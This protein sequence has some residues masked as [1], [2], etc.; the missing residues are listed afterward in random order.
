MGEMN[1]TIAI[2]GLHGTGKSTF[3]K[4]VA[5][6][7]GLRH[8]SVGELFRQMASEQHLSLTELSQEVEKRD[9]IDRLLDERTMEEIRKGSVVVDSLLASWMMKEHLTLKIYLSAPFE[10]RISRIASRDETSY[11]EAEKATVLRERIERRRFK[12]LY[13]IDIDDLGHVDTLRETT[14]GMYISRSLGGVPGRT[15]SLR[16]VVHGTEYDAG[17]VD[18][19]YFTVKN[20]D[21]TGWPSTPGCLEDPDNCENNETVYKGSATNQ[22]R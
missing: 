6:E 5:K 17:D 10:T 21:A 2:S 22:R 3:A 18:A 1:L 8:V 16:V 15:Y 19:G 20:Y 4:S 14:G 9:A 7:F 11:I 13:S 12:S